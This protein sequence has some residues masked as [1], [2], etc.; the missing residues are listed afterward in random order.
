MQRARLLLSSLSRPV[1][2]VVS[3]LLIFQFALSRSIP[4]EESVPLLRSLDEFPSSVGD[5]ITLGDMPLESEVLDLLKADSTLNRVYGAPGDPQSVSL[6]IAYFKTQKAGVSPHSPKVCLPGSGWV[7][8]DS[9]LL[10]ISVP[11]HPQPIRVNRYVVSKG[12]SRS[13][14]LYWYQNR[15]RV[16]ASEFTAKFYSI[17]DSIRYRRSD[18]SLVRVV[19]PVLDGDEDEAAQVATRFV[20]TVSPELPRYLP[21]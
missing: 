8:S 9:S 6:F 16:I 5:W 17:Y 10:D 7:P 12:T 19:V 11:T 14:V 13:L 18:T 3:L 21:D 1:P 4:N 2:L 15:G 20:Q